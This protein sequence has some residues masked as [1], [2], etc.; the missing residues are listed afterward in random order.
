MLKYPKLP[1]DAHIRTCQ[2]CGSKQVAKHPK[3]YKSDI[4]KE[5]KCANCK[6]IGSLD[7]G[8]TN[9]EVNEDED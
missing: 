8:Q 2:E 5:L 1:A 6:S 4:W 9:T 7:Y 3:E